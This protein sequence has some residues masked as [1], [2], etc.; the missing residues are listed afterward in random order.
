MRELR[1]RVTELR[2]DFRETADDT[3]AITADMTRQYK[4]MERKFLDDI[5]KL[6]DRIRALEDELGKADVAEWCFV[7]RYVS[8]FLR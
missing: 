2:S 6:E 7:L 4:A 1:G 3:F 8:C 5:T